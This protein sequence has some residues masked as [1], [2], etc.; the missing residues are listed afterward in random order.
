[1][2]LLFKG[3]LCASILV[4]IAAAAEDT[5]TSRVDS[6]V[7]K[8][9]VRVTS[10]STA[11]VGASLGTGFIVSREKA[12]GQET[13]REYYLVTNK[14]VVGDWTLFNR[15]IANYFPAIQVLF[16]AGTAPTPTSPVTI[17]ITNSAGAADPRRLRV[18]KNPLIDVAVVALTPDILPFRPETQTSFDPSYMLSFDKITTYLTGLGD[19]VFA[20]GYPRG[21]TSLTT[22]YPIAKAGYLATQP[23]QVFAIELTGTDRSGQT[24]KARLE[25]KILVVDGLLVPGNSGG[26]VVLPSELKVRRDPVTNQLQF[27]TQQLKNY[28]IG[29]VSGSLNGSGLT[30]VYSVDYVLEVVDDFAGDPPKASK[31]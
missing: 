29:I 22:F 6:S 3:L 9:V 11:G 20:L 31:P 26:P 13:E 19:Q 28:V 5:N 10:L 14:H 15:T 12:V 2:R 24:T 17:T 1:M 7:L 8:A 16:Y 21:I 30:L 27:A 18:H 25:G 4:S 23:G